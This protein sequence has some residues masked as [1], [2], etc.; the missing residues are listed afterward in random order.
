M[1]NMPI[2]EVVCRMLPTICPVGEDH[3]QECEWEGIETFIQ[4]TM[5]DLKKW[6]QKTKIHTCAIMMMADFNLM[7]YYLT[8]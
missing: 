4:N 3:H 6:L 8:E 1:G 5:D 2:N 7:N